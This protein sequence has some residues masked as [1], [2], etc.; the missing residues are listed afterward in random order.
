VLASSARIAAIHR[1]GVTVVAA[2]G[3]A[4]AAAPALAC[5]VA[6]ADVLVGAGG[7]VREGRVLAARDRVAAVG[8]AV[9]VVV[10]AGRSADDARAALTAFRAVADGAVGARGTVADRNVLAA[11]NGVA[12]VG[13]A[14]VAVIAD[15]WCPLHT[16]T[17]LADLD[18][19]TWVAVRA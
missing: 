1:A 11:G 18:T 13:G 8:G 17:E 3:S 4:T 15:E 12:T 10:T 6:I 5:L 2:E 16:R 7:A 19:V 9:V 14:H